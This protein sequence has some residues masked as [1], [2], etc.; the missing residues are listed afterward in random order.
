M[1]QIEVTMIP[2]F[3]YRTVPLCTPDHL[4]HVSIFFVK[5]RSRCAEDAK[6]STKMYLTA[7]PLRSIARKTNDVDNHPERA[8]L[9]VSINDFVTQE[10]ISTRRL[11]HNRDFPHPHILPQLMLPPPSLA[12]HSDHVPL[13]VA[14]YMAATMGLDIVIL[15]APLCDIANKPHCSKD[16][17]HCT[18][19]LQL[20]HR[21]PS[22]DEVMLQIVMRDWRLRDL[23]N[24][25]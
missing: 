9:L 4:T 5:T 20:T 12:L 25:P 21:Q 6:K 15:A 22:T 17:Q 23:K 3:N 7:L 8:A 1:N 2:I 13:N 10:L 19:T 18:V 16:A 11:K 24:R 14:E